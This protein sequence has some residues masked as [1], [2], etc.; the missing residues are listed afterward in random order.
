MTNLQRITRRHFFGRAGGF[1]I[2][3]AALAA[4]L[5]EDLQ[6]QQKGK[7]PFDFAPKAK[8]V[9]FL[10]MAGAPSHLD[11]F[12]YKPKLQEMHGKPIPESLIK[13]ERFAFIRG[14][15]NIQ[16]SLWEFKRYGQ[17][18]ATLSSLLPALSTVVDDIS[19]VR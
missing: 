5:G 16:R 6:A 11:L 1:G 12:D 4:L 14:V 8:R 7:H 9:I 18:G 3:T 19:F 15:P 17:S 13:G 2:G 10:S